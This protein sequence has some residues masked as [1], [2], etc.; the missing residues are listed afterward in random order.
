VLP[1]WKATAKAIRAW[2]AVRR[3]A[4]CP[5]LFLNAKGGPITRDGFEYILAK[6]VKTATAAMPSLKKGSSAKPVG[7]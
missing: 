7:T 2:L 4:T 6:H 1:L 3:G 5:E